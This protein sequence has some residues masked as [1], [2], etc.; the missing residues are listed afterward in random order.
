MLEIDGPERLKGKKLVVAFL[1]LKE[2]RNINRLFR[3]RDY[4][5]D[6]LSFSSSDPGVLGE[7]AICPK[8]ISRQAKEHGILVRE[9]MGYMILHG[10]LHLLGYDHEGSA[11]QAKKMFALQDKVF[12]RLLKPDL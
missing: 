4:A 3:K 2:A 5:T 9:E 11:A 10:I 8:V 7:L 12:T 6:V 1:D